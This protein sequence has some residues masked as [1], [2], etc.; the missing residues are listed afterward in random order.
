MSGIQVKR[1]YDPPSR[2][3][4]SRILVDR[5]WPRG[6]TREKLRLTHWLKDIAPSDTLRKWFNHDPAKWKEF[7]GRY[8]AELKKNPEALEPLL[9][10][11]R[12]GTVTLLF[13]AK[14]TEHNN[15]IALKDFLERHKARIRTKKSNS[16]PALASRVRS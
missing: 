2:D 1:A 4:G 14:D 5:L 16:R 12:N 8:F 3:D 9:D 15:A 11:K 10:A 7:Q 6:L 13:G